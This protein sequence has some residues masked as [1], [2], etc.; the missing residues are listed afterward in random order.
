MMKTEGQL[1]EHFY[2][3]NNLGIREWKLSF[4][5]HSI[6]HIS[7]VLP[8]CSLAAENKKVGT[9]FCIVSRF[10]PRQSRRSAKLLF[11]VLLAKR[12]LAVSV[13]IGHNIFLSSHSPTQFTEEVLAS[14]HITACI[15]L[16]GL[17]LARARPRIAIINKVARGG[18]ICVRTVPV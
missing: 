7:A 18:G 4:F 17:H 16:G 11:F 8:V 15:R 5:F 1:P 12:T 6:E 9:L 3:S 10:F 2:Q 14:G 13:S